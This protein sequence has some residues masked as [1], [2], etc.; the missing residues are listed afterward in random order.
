MENKDSLKKVIQSLGTGRTY[1]ALQLVQE[2]PEIAAL[3]SKLIAPQDKSGF[4][5]RKPETQNNLNQSQ[6]QAISESTKQRVR[7]NEN[8]IQLFPD[9]ELAVQILI[10]SILSPKD[11]VKTDL[12]YKSREPILPS[13]LLLK[14]NTIVQSHLESYHGL[15]GELQD[16]LRETLFDTGSYIKAIIPESIVD[17][18]IN[19]NKVVSTESLTDLFDSGKKVRHLGILGNSGATKN[20]TALESFFN[21]NVTT[22]YRSSITYTDIHSKSGSI[23]LEHLEVTDNFQLLKL[24]EVI[25]AANKQKLKSIVSTSKKLSLEAYNEKAS[26]DKKLSAYELTGLAYKN[27]SPQ[28]QTFLSIPSRL[29]SKRKTIGRPLVLKLSSEAVIPVYIPGD[30]S[31]HIGYFVLVDNDGNPVNRN[32]VDS[33]SEGLT[34]LMGANNQGSGSG[35]SLSSMLIAKAKKNLGSN[36]SI[37]T[38]DRITKV[39]TSIVEQDLMERL[40]NGIYGSN[41]QV[42]NNEEIYRIMLA[43]SLSSKFT[44]LIYLPAELA[45]YFAFD[46]YPNGVGKSYLDSIKNLTSLRAILL[47]SKVMA[48]VKSA[49]SLTH[50]AMTLDPNDPDPQKTIELAQQ[51]IVKMRQQYFPLGINSPVDLVDWIQRAGLEFSFEGHPGLPQTKFDFEAKTMQRDVPDSELDEMLRKQTY[52]AFGLSPETVDNGFNSEF[53]TS[54]VANNILLSKR[55]IQ[56]QNT[57][58]PLLTEYGQKLILNDAIAMQELKEILEKNLGLVEKSLSDEEKSVFTENKDAFLT[59]VVERFIDNFEIDLPHPDITSLESQSKAFED[60]ETALDKALESWVSTQFMTTDLIGDASTNIDSIKAV[61]KAY[62]LRRWM[63]DNGY[64]PELN[65]IVTADEDGAAT[66]DIYDMNKNHMEGL[67][68][69]CLK[70]LKSIQPTLLASNADLLKMGI[71][72]G[73]PSADTSSD[74]SSSDDGGDFGDMGMGD[75]GGDI[76]GDAV[77]VPPEEVSDVVTDDTTEESKP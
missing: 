7:D 48:Q 4:N 47:F 76:D 50:V 20:S 64:M 23:T 40:S 68:R 62:Y 73:E 54:V 74:S 37:P 35:T 43:R 46:Y 58:T 56:L 45:T 57:F 3:I 18:I 27:N 53:A 75:L 31:R 34:G 63:A 16:M 24:P 38:I 71:S 55:V 14:L 67:L 11:M 42:G 69:S 12:I 61:V 30:E 28:S 22:D 72:E 44:R 66:I 25:K 70:F 15:R 51:E 60:Y 32:S 10:S 49:I 41:V 19:Q 13:E 29:N 6:I 36:D 8:I 33:S 52:M 21:T 77:D 39:Y 2:S 17:E 1:P 59:S 26:V 5:P 65:D 9:I